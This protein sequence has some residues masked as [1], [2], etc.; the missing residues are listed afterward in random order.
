MAIGGCTDRRGGSIPYNVSDFGAPDPLSSLALPK[1]Y[2]IAPMDTLSIRVFGMPDLTGEYQVD[3]L[4]NVAMPLV[5]D[6]SALDKSPVEFDQALTRKYSEKYLENPDISVAV[7]S[8]NG[9]LVTVDG[10]VRKGGAFPVI[11][12]MTLMQAIALA[13]G[14]DPKLAN[15]RRVAIFRTI[16]GKRQA[17]AFDLLSIQRGE[18]DDPSI[19][20]G[21]IVI[22]DGSNLKEMQENLLRTIPL[23]NIF[24]P[25]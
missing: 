1:D 23:F 14:A 20:S 9:R 13:G 5:G 7:K 17:A 24:R 21:D 15:M 18:M 4:G 3:L 12:R 22:V 8:S 25:F 16:D 19:Y 10:A 6:V 2:K 11:G